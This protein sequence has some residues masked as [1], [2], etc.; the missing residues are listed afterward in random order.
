MHVHVTRAHEAY[1]ATPTS[2]TRASASLPRAS[3]KFS[4][5]V[6]EGKANKVI[7]HELGVAE[8]TVKVYRAQMMRKLSVRSSAELG[9]LAEQLRNLPE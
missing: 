7:A 9:A 8:R 4:F 5:E 6:T 3:G 1:A 2:C